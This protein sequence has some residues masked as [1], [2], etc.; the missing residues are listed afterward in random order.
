M[1]QACST[2][3]EEPEEEDRGAKVLQA[4]PRGKPADMEGEGA[5]SLPA[6]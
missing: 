5:D 3:P 4:A 1:F 6:Q 2:I